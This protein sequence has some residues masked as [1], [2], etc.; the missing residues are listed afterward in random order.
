MLICA[1]WAKRVQTGEGERID[2][3]MADVC[4]AWVG[5]YDTVAH[6]DRDTPAGGSPGYGVFRA[7]DGG[8]VTL[9]VISEDHFWRA[10]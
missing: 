5:P 7:A 2:V 8:Y 3:A 6:R 1:A 9:A 10:V 4:A